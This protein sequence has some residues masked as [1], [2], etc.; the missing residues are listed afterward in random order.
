MFLCLGKYLFLPNL[1][2]IIL[3]N[4]FIFCFMIRYTARYRQ[5]IIPKKDDLC[6]AML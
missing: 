6:I 1:K 5:S 4:Y 3:I 2:N